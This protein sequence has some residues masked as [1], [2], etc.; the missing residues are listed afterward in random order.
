MKIIGFGQLRNELSQGN[1]INWFKSMEICDYIYIY[2]QASTDGSKEYYKKFSNTV[3]I[4]SP[5]NNFKREVF[6]K[7]ELLEKIKK[8]HPDP[9]WCHWIDGDTFLDGEM[10]K[11]NGAKTREMLAR[12]DYNN[13]DSLLVGH[14]NL[15]RSDV[16]YRTD[17][18]YHGGHVRAFWKN[19]PDVMFNPKE[20]LHVTTIPEGLHNPSYCEATVIHRGFAT[21]E[22]IIRK[23]LTYE[24]FGQTGWELDRLIDESTLHVERISDNLIPEW[25]TVY[26]TESPTNKT[27]LKEAYKGL[28]P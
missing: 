23:Y 6:C 20:G 24:S 14:Y 15:W 4:E 9:H 12:A 13:Y 1:L 27:T 19:T 5:I 7:A 18:Q 8:D 28:I 11:N 22:N 21:D 25:Y 3:V 2:D 26:D 10:L 16:W 17:Q